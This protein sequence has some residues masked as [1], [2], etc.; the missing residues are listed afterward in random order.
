[1]NSKIFACI[2]APTCLSLGLQYIETYENIHFG[3][4][5][6]TILLNINNFNYFICIIMLLFDSLLYLI[7][8]YYFNQIIYINNYEIKLIKNPLFLAQSTN[9]SSEKTSSGERLLP[10]QSIA[11]ASGS[12]HS[13]ILFHGC[14]N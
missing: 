12:L 6:N 10:I 13:I 1:M 3:L 5:Y 7:I 11:V 14:H 9:C 2:S 8:A 4:K